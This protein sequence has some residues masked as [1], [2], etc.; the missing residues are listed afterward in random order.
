MPFLVSVFIIFASPFASATRPS[1]SLEEVI[2]QTPLIFEGVVVDF[3]NVTAPNRETYFANDN[4]ALEVTLKISKSWKGS[5]KGQLKVF[6]WALGKAPCSGIELKRNEAYLVYA[7]W[8]M[9][10]KIVTF[11]FC[12][13]LRPL[14]AVYT[15]EDLA[16]LKRLFP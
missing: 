2:Q 13:G 11:D 9:S 3:A 5:L 14:R 7:D 8:D 10:K 16:I 12:R 15:Q 1:V 6:T 4:K